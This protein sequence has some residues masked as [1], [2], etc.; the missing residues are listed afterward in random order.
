MDH[1]RR[2]VDRGKYE[3]MQKPVYVLSHLYDD[4]SSDDE[5][6]GSMNNLIDSDY[7][8]KISVHSADLDFVD[9]LFRD[10]DSVCD[11]RNVVNETD[12]I[13]DTREVIVNSDTDSESD[14]TSDPTDENNNRKVTKTTICLVMN[15]TVRRAPCGTEEIS[16]IYSEDLDPKDIDFASVAIDILNEVPKHFNVN[17]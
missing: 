6:G 4:I 8:E 13:K 9:E 16:I 12:E 10:S 15:R 17:M 14:S 11:E 7:L 2:R 3:E 1:K 5:F